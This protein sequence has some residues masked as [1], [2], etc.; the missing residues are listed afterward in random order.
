[1]S[2]LTIELDSLT[3]DRLQEGSRQE[4]RG[5]AKTAARLLAAFLAPMPPDDAD[6]RL[7][8]QR[9]AQFWVAEKWMPPFCVP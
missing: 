4:G 7:L 8:E 9:D 5:K 6:A 2:S 3:E 1:M